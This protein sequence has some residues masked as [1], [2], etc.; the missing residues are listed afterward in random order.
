MMLHGGKTS[1]K[2]KAQTS[3]T[4]ETELLHDERHTESEFLEETTEKCTSRRR[5]T[6]KEIEVNESETSSSRN[7]ASPHNEVRTRY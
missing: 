1:T 4:T 5:I 7:G 2:Q 3:A 6:E